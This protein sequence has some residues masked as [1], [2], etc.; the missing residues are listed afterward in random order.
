MKCRAEKGEAGYLQLD[1]NRSV[2]KIH[3]NGK[4][5]RG[6]IKYVRIPPRRE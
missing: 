1:S 2:D 6:K 3:F 5:D 4:A